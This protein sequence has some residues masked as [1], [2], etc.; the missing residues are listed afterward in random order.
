MAK[1]ANPYHDDPCPQGISL[2]YSLRF[3]I[4]NFYIITIKCMY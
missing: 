2:E 3:Y 1:S 4:N